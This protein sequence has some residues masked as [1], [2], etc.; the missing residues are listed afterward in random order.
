M[1]ICEELD[2][3]RAANQRSHAQ[4][5]PHDREQ[6]TYDFRRLKREQLMGLLD[7][8]DKLLRGKPKTL[9]FGAISIRQPP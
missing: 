2:E 6:D 9:P 8:Y 4:D 5:D 1:R 7:D 3:A